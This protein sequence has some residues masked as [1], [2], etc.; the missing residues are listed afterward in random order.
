MRIANFVHPPFGPKE[1]ELNKKRPVRTRCETRT[2]T[3]P[4]HPPV[5]AVRARGLPFLLYRAMLPE[6]HSRRFE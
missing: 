2:L 4:M 3:G 6:N 1:L 5:V